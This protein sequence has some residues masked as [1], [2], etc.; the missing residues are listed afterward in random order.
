MTAAQLS[1]LSGLEPFAVFSS[2]ERHD[3]CPVAACKWRHYRY[4]LAWPTGIDNDQRALFVLANPSTAT[5]DKLDPTLTRCLGYAQAWGFGWF[6]VVNVRAWR[7][8]DPKDVP[9][10]ERGVGPDNDAF[11][12]AAV[13]D[14]H[15]IVCGWGNLGADRAEHVLGII[16]DA[17]KTPH[18]L[19][20]NKRSGQPTHPLYLPSNLRPIA[21]LDRRTA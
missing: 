2:C 4:R 19:R 14:A 11:M 6:D 9:L 7:A 18:A 20:I 16:R 15:L 8:T 12:I 5:A 13:K 17:G 21:W 10:G 1:L 3:H